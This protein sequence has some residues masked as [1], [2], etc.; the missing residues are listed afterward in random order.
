MAPPPNSGDAKNTNDE[1]PLGG[2]DP[3]AWLESLAARQGAKPEELT[4]A[5][6]LD[7][8]VPPADT[9]IDEP[10]YTPGYETSKA[11][12][13][14]AEPA[15]PEPAKVEPPA[16]AP[17]P[18]AAAGDDPLG[19]MDPMKWLESLA[20]RQ[21]ANA[22]ELTTSADLEIPMPPADTVVDEPGYTPGYETSKAP[23]ASA[24]PARPEPAKVEPPAPAPEPVAVASD[25]PLGGMDPMKWLESLAAR[26]GANPEELTTAAN[27]DIPL[28]PADT[29]VDEPGYVDY[30]PFGSGVQRPAEPAKA[31]EPPAPAP[32]PE[33]A[34]A[35]GEDLL[36][37]MDPLAWLESLAARQG[38]NPEE[39]I[40]GGTLE[41][42]VP[43][44]ASVIDEP[45]YVDYSPFD[46]KQ[47]EPAPSMT[48]EEAAELLG[49][50]T[51]ETP[52][53]GE[54]ALGGMD[55]LAW[56]ESLAARQGANPEELVTGGTLELPA[57]PE[58]Q[59]D[60]S[61]FAATP[62]TTGATMEPESA[63]SWLEEL[64]REQTEP[65]AAASF[66]SEIVAEAS[67]SEAGGMSDNIDEVQAWLFE[68]AHKLEQTREELESQPSDEIAPAEAGELPDWL[69]ESATMAAVAPSTPA[70]SDE[71][72]TPVAPEDLPSWLVQPD[73]EVPL[74]FQSELLQEISASAPPP[75]P[76]APEAEPVPAAEIEAMTRPASPDDVD[77]WAEALDEEYDRRR[78]GD[79]SVP[80]W[81]L[82]ALSR[83]ES[84]IA[85]T[86]APAPVSQAPTPAAEPAVSTGMPDWLNDMAAV[87]TATEAMA[88]EIPDWLKDMSPTSAA[89][90]APALSTPISDDWLT[91]T[92][93]SAEAVELPDWLKPEPEPAPTPA[94]APV[95]KA[96]EPTPVA[97]PQPTPV[98]AMP[99][100][101]PQPAPVPTPAPSRPPMPVPANIQ[102]RLTRA[103]GL[104]ANDQYAASLE[105]YQTLIDTSQLL[106]E[107]RGD[108]RQLV[109]KNPQ[110]PKLRRLLGDTH[111]RLGDL[112]AALDTY[113]SALDQL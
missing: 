81:Y 88:G 113:R 11:P 7:I 38:A 17:E 65:L 73:S 15:R 14:S 36:G 32:T 95:Q 106:E 74:D 78:A 57:A 25:D 64:A 104:V 28:P 85:E 16:P 98:Q 54:D 61:P 3:M 2:M 44:A 50:G 30:D 86:P 69:R 101:A 48:A 43:D 40:T 59:A 31:P 51:N 41:V 23:A 92:D 80:D 97:A 67:P 112:Q 12:A 58:P 108:L 66:E 105:D 82:E 55:P 35:G 84:E 91:Q 76:S 99:T 62:E 93:T 100:P 18:V 72:I 20:A 71:I 9:V 75:A 63:L 37:G 87:D 52:S 111:M 79:E 83:A 49:V 10:G 34:A 13:A 110:D 60:M 68:Q 1:D 4:T 70:L 103:R 21:G 5:A 47:A 33:P 53:A 96:P 42:P 6:N 90:A 8:P 56:L 109:D 89:E 102:E 19:G 46:E 45:G 39:L 27:L 77:S 29:V 107:T 22:A 26:Q 24:E 94:P